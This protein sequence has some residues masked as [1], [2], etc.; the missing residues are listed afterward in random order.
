M[1]NGT[2]LVGPLVLGCH[3]RIWTLFIYFFCEICI[4]SGVEVENMWFADV[5]WRRKRKIR[6]WMKQRKRRRK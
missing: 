5:G 4:A 6:L 2:L 1:E 3:R